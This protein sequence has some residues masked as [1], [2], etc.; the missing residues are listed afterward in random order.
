[1]A[2]A[3]AALVN[4]APGL[5]HTFAETFVDVLRRHSAVN[6]AD[7]TCHECGQSAPCTTRLLLEDRAVAL[8]T[9]STGP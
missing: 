3:L 6:D 5:L 9:F 1:M 8:R 7:S 2:R 4:D